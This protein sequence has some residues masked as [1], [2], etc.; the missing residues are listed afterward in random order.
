MRWPR[1][2]VIKTAPLRWSLGPYWS[3]SSLIPRPPPY[4]RQSL[5]LS[6][7]GHSEHLHLMP[8]RCQ[9]CT[10]T[11]QTTIDGINI[12]TSN[13]CTCI[14]K[15]QNQAQHINTQRT[16]MIKNL[17]R[18]LYHIWVP[19]E[20]HRS[21]GELEYKLRRLP[22]YQSCLLSQVVPTF[23]TA[24]ANQNLGPSPHPWI[25]YHWYLQQHPRPQHQHPLQ[26]KGYQDGAKSE[27]PPACGPTT[28]QLR[29]HLRVKSETPSE[30]LPAHHHPLHQYQ[31]ATTNSV[32]CSGPVHPC[33]HCCYATM[34]QNIFRTNTH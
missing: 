18:R 20:I 16:S 9:I 23:A 22:P 15:S 24:V 31:L 11:K 4:T 26:E 1:T 10:C 6:L 34:Q 5:L 33:Y 7:R 12:Y 28:V 25:S 17:P 8:T 3:L 19:P 13:I 27:L 32:G 29:N 2:R 21:I 14:S 30:P